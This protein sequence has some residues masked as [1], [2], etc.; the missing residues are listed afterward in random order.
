MENLINGVQNEHYFS[1]Y[2]NG[3]KTDIKYYSIIII[4]LNISFFKYI[5]S[6]YNKLY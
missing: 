5:E 6:L 3:N 4:Q 1:K 2:L